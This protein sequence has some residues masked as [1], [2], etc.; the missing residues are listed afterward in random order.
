VF[1]APASPVAHRKALIIVELIALIH[2]GK[3][4]TTFHFRVIT[5][6]IMEQNTIW[7]RIQFVDVL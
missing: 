7:H 4:S 6:I 5:F 2:T 3:V 1:S